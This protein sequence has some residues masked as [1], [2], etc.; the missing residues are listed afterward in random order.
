MPAKS[1][2]R[3]ETESAGISFYYRRSLSAG[4]LLPAIGIGVAA[5]LVAFYLARVV[6]QRTPLVPARDKPVGS[7][8]EGP[9]QPRRLMQSRFAG[10]TSR[11]L[12][13]ATVL[14]V[15]RSS[16]PARAGADR[17][18]LVR[19]RAARARSDR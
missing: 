2:P 18:H 19:P 7:T 17:R 12:V 9:S 15:A 8:L 14:A 1:D 13:L 5:G 16:A 3:D 11:A 6:M 10:I 4:E